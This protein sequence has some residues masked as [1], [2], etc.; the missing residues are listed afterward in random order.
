MGVTYD[1]SVKAKLVAGG[2]ILIAAATGFIVWSV[3]RSQAAKH[4][5]TPFAAVTPCGPDPSAHGPQVSGYRLPPEPGRYVTVRW[6]APGHLI[7]FATVQQTQD[8]K[9]WVLVNCEGAVP[10]AKIPPR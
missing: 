8:G 9:S 1:V 5:T 2:L 7:R 4:Y 6:N 10:R 3:N